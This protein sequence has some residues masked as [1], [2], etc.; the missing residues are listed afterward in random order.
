MFWADE[1]R[2]SPSNRTLFASTRGLEP[3]TKGWVAAFELHESGA[4]KS[5]SQ[6]RCGQHQPVVVGPMPL[7]PAPFTPTTAQDVSDQSWI[8]LTDS[9]EGLIMILLWQSNRLVEVQRL[10]LMV[11]L[12]LLS[13]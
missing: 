8:V 13:G 7:N 6:S 1:V 10:R 11:V 9:E 3:R 4:I 2:L 5:E 12:L